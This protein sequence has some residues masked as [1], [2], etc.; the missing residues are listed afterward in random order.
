MDTC[1]A[2]YPLSGIHP[3]TG[4]GFRVYSPDPLQGAK[5]RVTITMRRV[6][7]DAAVACLGQGR[8]P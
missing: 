6:E 4:A 2:Q 8:Q 1:N 5:R 3:L 7:R